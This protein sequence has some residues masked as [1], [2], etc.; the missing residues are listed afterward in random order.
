MRE[1]LYKIVSVSKDTDG[2]SLALW[3]VCSGCCRHLMFWPIHKFPGIRVSI[4]SQAGSLQS[5]PLPPARRIQ[6]VVRGGGGKEADRKQRWRP[7]R[8]TG[9]ADEEHGRSRGSERGQ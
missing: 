7:M 4:T 5:P 8:K 3:S 1:I 2:R 9:E 6:P